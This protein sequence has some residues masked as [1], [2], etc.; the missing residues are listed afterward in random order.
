MEKGEVGRGEKYGTL[1]SKNGRDKRRRRAGR[2]VGHL[3]FD[4]RKRK[5]KRKKVTKI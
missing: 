1:I 5:E 4:E 3:A 2:A